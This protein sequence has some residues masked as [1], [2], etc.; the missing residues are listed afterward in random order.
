MYI[1]RPIFVQ[2]FYMFAKNEREYSGRKQQMRALSRGAYKRNRPAAQLDRSAQ[3]AMFLISTSLTPAQM[4]H[5][6]AAQRST[7][8]IGQRLHIL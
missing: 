2:Y 1:I 5:R 3:S 6:A 4:K 8:A 7:Q